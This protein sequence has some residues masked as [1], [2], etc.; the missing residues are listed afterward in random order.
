MFYY[1]D[2]DDLSKQQP[3]TTDSSSQYNQ[4]HF[5]FWQDVINRLLAQA[6]RRYMVKEFIEY[7]IWV[8]R[9]YNFCIVNQDGMLYWHFVYVRRFYKICGLY[10]AKR[11][12]CQASHISMKRPFDLMWWTWYFLGLE[13]MHFIM[14]WRM[15]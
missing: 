13:D 11:Q 10:Y 9:S 6:K 1:L 4:I 14:R 2:F 15:M 12:T 3:L 7:F 8:H 5:S